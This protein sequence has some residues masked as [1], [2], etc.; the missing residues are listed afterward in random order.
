MVFNT[1]QF[2]FTAYMVYDDTDMSLVHHQVILD[3][4]GLSSSACLR[5]NPYY[6]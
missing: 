6:M 3:A 2:F 1:S 4:L 5:S